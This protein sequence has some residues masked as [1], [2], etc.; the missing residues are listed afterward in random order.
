M[1]ASMRARGAGMIDRLTR[2]LAQAMLAA[3]LVACGRTE[4][5]PP[6]PPPATQ[7]PAPRQESADDIEGLVESGPGVGSY[8]YEAYAY[9]CEGLAVAVRPGDGELKL[10]LPERTISLPQV[11]AAS[12]AKYADGDTVFW[13]KG[14][15]SATLTLDGEETNCQL[16]RQETP[17]TDARARGASF[18]GVGVEPG[19][20][21]EVHPD[22]LVFVYQ[23]GEKRAVLPNQ[24]PVE[25][26]E[27]RTR[28]WQTTSEEHEMG[29]VVEDRACTD[30]MSGAI[31]PATVH[32][33]LDGRSYMGCGRNLD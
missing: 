17:W 33:T 1:G 2:W 18:R 12:G 21:L 3:V 27:L 22:R 29:V 4:V 9:D 6:E 15:N 10:I 7:Q 24:G 14:M 32:V 16:D 20:H 25:D 23:Y 31:Y 8:R 11:E 26:S 30:V 5:P 13:G 19:W 28:R